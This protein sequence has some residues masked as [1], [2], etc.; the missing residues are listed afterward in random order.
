MDVHGGDELERFE[1]ADGRVSRVVT[2]AGSSSTATWWSIGAGVMPDVMLARRPASSWARRAACAARAGLESSVPGIYA[3]GD[4]CEYDSPVHGAAAARGALGRGLQPR[5]DGRAEH[6]RPW[7][8]ARRGAVLLLR[9]G[10]LGSIEYVGPGTGEPVV[11]G[12]LD[13]GEFTAFYV[14][15][16]RVTAGSRWAARTTWST[17]GRFLTSTGAP[18]APADHGRP[19][20]KAGLRGGPRRRGHRPQPGSSEA[21]GGQGLEPR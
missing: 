18:A 2:K 20:L 12:S 6:A 3:A 7:G 14:D 21:T 13:E 5:Q 1:G 19:A 10:R 11:R 15:G 4:I 17:S 16:G 9:P 8:R